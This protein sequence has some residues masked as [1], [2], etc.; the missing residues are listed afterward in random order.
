MNEMPLA[1]IR[2]DQ[3]GD[4]PTVIVDVREA[5]PE[6][7]PVTPDELKKAC[8]LGEPILL[9]FKEKVGSE[10]TPTDQRLTEAVK[11][12]YRRTQSLAMRLAHED[13]DRMRRI[14][15]SLRRAWQRWDDPREEV[16]VI[17]VLGHD[18]GFPFEL[19]PLFD[20]ESDPPS[21]IKRPDQLA[22]AMRRFVG[23]GAMVQRE[24]SAPHHAD[25]VGAT[26]LRI[27]FLRF[28]MPGAE[29]EYAFLS[30]IKDL[31]VE[32]PWPPEGLT[33][34]NVAKKLVDALINPRLVLK[35]TA[36]AKERD[37]PAHIVHFACHCHTDKKFDDD[38]EIELGRPV[39]PS[40]VTFYDLRQG[41]LKDAT[42]ASIRPLV[43]MNACGSSVINATTSASFQRW[44]LANGHRGFIGTETAVPDK[45]A[46]VFAKGLY[47]ALMDG[48]PLGQALVLARRSLVE[49][50]SN[51]LG[52]LWVIQAD[53][54]LR[55]VSA[56]GAPTSPASGR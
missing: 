16:P 55:L 6:P 32:G 29:S 54:R 9:Q 15:Q 4:G 44:F 24:T 33:E 19:L 17:E 34:S 49:N 14:G 25:T 35:D 2:V 13:G 42:S 41:F 7:L 12:L 20:M 40:K 50:C 11:L 56:R 46:A 8:E 51:P 31:D 1:Q 30:T 38:W 39:A 37:P 28:A 22:S 23:Y 43:F 18:F 3:S 21:S 10:T 53:P 27:R 48:Q 45:V 36:E 52:I 5:D 47:G 26:P